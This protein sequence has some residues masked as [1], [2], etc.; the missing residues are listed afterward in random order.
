MADG[1]EARC[2][3]SDVPRWRVLEKFEKSASTKVHRHSR[4]PKIKNQGEFAAHDSLTILFELMTNDKKEK[5]M[6]AFV[7]WRTSASAWR[8]EC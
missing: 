6:C 8:V 2:A 3:K 5:D 1:G 4:E 7:S